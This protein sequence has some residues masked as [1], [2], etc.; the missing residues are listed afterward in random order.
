MPL[1]ELG[2]QTV[3][4]DC[5]PIGF[6]DSMGVFTLEKVGMKDLE[7]ERERE[8]VKIIFKMKHFNRIIWKMAKCGA[9]CFV[10]L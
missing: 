8:R 3:I 7:G 6:I 10:I 5:G 2:H 1:E 9:H 4:I